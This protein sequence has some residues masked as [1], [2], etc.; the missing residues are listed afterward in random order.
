M[1]SL[2]LPTELQGVETSKR[3][4]FMSVA[5]TPGL[6]QGSVDGS[7][8]N[9][10]DPNNV[11]GSNNSWQSEGVNDSIEYKAFAVAP[12]ECKE[13]VD[14][15]PIDSLLFGKACGWEKDEKKF[16]IV[17]KVVRTIDSLTLYTPEQM[18]YKLHNDA[19]TR[20]GAAPSLEKIFSDW[21]LAGINVS[22][23]VGISERQERISRNGKRVGEER[24]VVLRPL[25]D[26]NL[27][28]YF[29]T[30][31]SGTE[32]SAI[33]L[34]LYERELTEDSDVY[35]CDREGQDQKRLDNVIWDA[36]GKGKTKRIRSVPAWKAVF[37]DNRVTPNKEDLEYEIT[38]TTGKKVKKY[39]DFYWRIGRVKSNPAYKRVDFNMEGVF[40]EMPKFMEL[41]NMQ[42]SC[43]AK[44]L[45]VL[46]NL[47]P[48]FT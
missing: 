25:N 11:V 41:R 38:D 30:T 27:I 35:V 39:T 6:G 17:G 47:Q 46:L 43:D 48:P 42:Q 4:R 44:K 26:G 2:N 15:Y 21:K 32:N 13:W 7:S 14:N 29:G 3:A 19:L 33:F 31:V 23:P 8:Y 36:S 20:K 24:V 5:D 22:P 28:G 18:N 12:L 10:A 9:P 40:R 34:V 37:S 16:S 45:V 1:G